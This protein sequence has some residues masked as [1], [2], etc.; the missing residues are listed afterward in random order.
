VDIAGLSQVRLQVEP[1]IDKRPNPASIGENRERAVPRKVS[2]TSDVGAFVAD[3]MRR[4]ITGMGIAT[5][6][7]GATHV[8][9]GEV[10]QFFVDET[11]RYR[12][13]VLVEVTLTD[14]SGKTLWTGSANGSATRF[15]HSYKADNYY[16]CLSDS[17][18]QATFYLIK[19]PTFHDALAKP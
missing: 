15:G 13:D 5:V 12:S 3:R 14:A 7:T 16:E 17:L 19:N 18:L 4:I 10:K 9:K 2:T 11:N 6:D 1:F 8:L